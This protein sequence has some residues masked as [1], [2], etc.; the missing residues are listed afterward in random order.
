MKTTEFNLKTLHLGILFLVCAEMSHAQHFNQVTGTPFV[1]LIYSSMAFADI[2]ND[3]DADLLITGQDNHLVRMTKLYTNDG[4]GNFTEITNA[5]FIGL[6]EGSIAFANVDGDNDQDLLITG[7]SDSG[8]VSKLYINNGLG[9]FTEATGLPFEQVYQSAIAFAD[10]DGDDDQDVLI[11]GQNGMYN[12]IAKLYKND[13]L[14]NFTE[15]MNTPFVG[16]DESSIAFADVDGDNDQD[17]LIT[18]LSSAG[19]VSKLYSN[20][21]MGNFTEM[22]G[23]PMVG[24]AASSVAFADIDGDNDQDL[25][26]TGATNTDRISK[27]YMNNGSGSFTEVLNTPFEG[28]AFSS[29]A[30]ADVDNDNDQDVFITGASFFSMSAKL[31]INNGAG[32]FTEMMNTPFDPVNNGSVA[33]ADVD[34][35]SDPDLFI[36]GQ[37]LSIVNH[38]SKLYIND[39][40]LASV[41]DLTTKNRFDISAFPNPATSGH[42][43]IQFKT[44][45]NHN[46]M[47]RLYDQFGRLVSQQSAFAESIEQTLRIDVSGLPA[48]SYF[49]HVENGKQLGRTKFIVQ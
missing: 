18:G 34:G 17:L 42:V 13:G 41:K 28:V 11:T 19:Y 5:P 29:I 39:G 4:S 20:D 27:L 48:G 16:V 9:N 37:N 38:I 8:Y 2:D 15:V 33:F 31:Y 23:T 3:N 46:L 10:V 32:N 45:D 14:G 49:V 43:D 36:I 40:I 22:T 44:M 7:R 47:L 21:G 12:P 24:I 35:D 25:L 30:F 1:G 6:S 26:V